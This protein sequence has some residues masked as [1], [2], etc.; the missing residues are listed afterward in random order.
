MTVYCQAMAEP[1]GHDGDSS[2][3]QLFCVCLKIC[4]AAFRG[5]LVA[6][7]VKVRFPSEFGSKLWVGL[8]NVVADVQRLFA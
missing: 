5:Y 7:L 2:V 4:F 6:P 8:S 3:E 1:I